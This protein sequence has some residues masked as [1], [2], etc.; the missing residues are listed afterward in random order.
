MAWHPSYS[1][2]PGSPGATSLKYILSGV[3]GHGHGVEPAKSSLAYSNPEVNLD[4][5]SNES[6]ALAQA[7]A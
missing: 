2:Y 5:D 3:R 6:K 4:I 1:S 7:R